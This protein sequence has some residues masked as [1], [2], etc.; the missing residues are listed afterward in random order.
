MKLSGRYSETNPVISVFSFS[1][2]YSV[3]LSVSVANRAA[4]ILRGAKGWP[5]RQARSNMPA[6]TAA[7]VAFT[8]G[9]I[10]GASAGGFSRGLVDD[11]CDAPIP[12][13][14]DEK[15]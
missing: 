13:F 5:T 10:N 4:S 1:A 6:Q 8:K 7:S 12:V 3:S 15:V 11:C 2:T 14:E 9:R